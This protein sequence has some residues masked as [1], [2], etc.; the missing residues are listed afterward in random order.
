[1]GE[2]IEMPLG[3]GVCQSGPTVVE[4]SPKS[5]RP[6]AVVSIDDAALMT[7]RQVSTSRKLPVS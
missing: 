7:L 3:S 5:G 4:R 2:P 6:K 1:M